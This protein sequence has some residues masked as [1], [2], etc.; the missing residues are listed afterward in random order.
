MGKLPLFSLS[1]NLSSSLYLQCA[2]FYGNGPEIHGL[3]S[4]KATID[5][6]ILLVTE[7]ASRET[8]FF[9]SSQL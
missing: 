1:L 7:P 5:Y 6:K 9:T 3:L 2:L 8:F 4:P